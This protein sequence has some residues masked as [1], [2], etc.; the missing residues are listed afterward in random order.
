M[1]L[2]KTYLS[3]SFGW[4][5]QK[6]TTLIVHDHGLFYPMADRKMAMP[7]DSRGT[8]CEGN[9]KLAHELK[10]SRS[11]EVVGLP[12]R[13]FYA[14]ISVKQFWATDRILDNIK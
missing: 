14:C 7:S 1:K 13:K 6:T 12:I 8:S 10:V 2:L 5:S 9:A 11:L 4:C 3:D